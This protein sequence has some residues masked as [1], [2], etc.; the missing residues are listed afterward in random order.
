MPILGLWIA[1]WKIRSGNSV[2]KSRFPKIALSGKQ[3]FGNY[4][5]PLKSTSLA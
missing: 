5:Q 2:R 1:D 3:I 4:K